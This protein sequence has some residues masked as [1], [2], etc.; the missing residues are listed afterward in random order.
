MIPIQELLNR[1]RWDREFGKGSFEVGYFDHKEQ[2]LLRVPFQK[3]VFENGN[4][5]SF[6]TASSEGEWL[7]I[8]FH[9]VREVFKDGHPI[10]QRRR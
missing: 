10:W 2:K 5:F 7:T 6:Q 1:I 9:R 3:M 8:P 4:H